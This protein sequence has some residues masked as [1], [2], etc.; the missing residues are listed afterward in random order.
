MTK[1]S[2]LPQSSKIIEGANDAS[3]T[4]IH[5]LIAEEKRKMNEQFSDADLERSI[6]MMEKYE[7]VVERVYELQKKVK[8][9]EDRY[10]TNFKSLW[11]VLSMT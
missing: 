5:N 8:G 9:L 6:S 2:T 4:E 10:E 7:D 1:N 3:F 11:N